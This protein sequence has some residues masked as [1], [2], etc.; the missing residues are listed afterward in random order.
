MICLTYIMNI[1]EIIPTNNN[2][3]LCN[4]LNIYCSM[5]NIFNILY[6]NFILYYATYNSIFT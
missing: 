3:T 1:L 6:F 4:M 5:P 2:H